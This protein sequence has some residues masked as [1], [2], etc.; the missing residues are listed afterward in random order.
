M[1]YTATFVINCFLELMHVHLV[2]YEIQSIAGT[3]VYIHVN[4]H[5][6]NIMVDQFYILV[7]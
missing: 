7:A 1:K 5:N 3:Y 4:E 6:N 2:G